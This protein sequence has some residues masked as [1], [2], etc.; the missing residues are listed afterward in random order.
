MK[1]IYK[2]GDRQKS[3]AMPDRRFGYSWILIPWGKSFI[4]FYLCMKRLLVKIRSSLLLIIIYKFT[5][6]CN[7][8]QVYWQN[9][10][11]RIFK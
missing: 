11:T 5:K 8:L 2:I 6:H 9:I 10:Q 3:S 1:K 4:P 7:Y